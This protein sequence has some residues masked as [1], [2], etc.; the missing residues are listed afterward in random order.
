MEF[1]FKPPTIGP[2]A[3]LSCGPSGWPETFSRKKADLSLLAYL[4]NV[5]A[6]QAAVTEYREQHHYDLSQFDWKS[7]NE[8]LRSRAD[9]LGR[10]HTPDA[11][12]AFWAASILANA[13]MAYWDE[14]H[15]PE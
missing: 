15:G 6:L 14:Y 12:I 2:R 5:E 11:A 7:I 8:Y 1:S 9:E 10:E 3:Y 13:D 4:G